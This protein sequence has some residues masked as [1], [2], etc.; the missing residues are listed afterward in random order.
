MK[1]TW[2]G[3]FITRMIAV[4]M[5]FAFTLISFNGCKINEPN[6]NID[7]KE[8]ETYTLERNGLS[9][10]KFTNKVDGYS[11]RIPNNMDVDM[12]LSGVRSVLE[13]KDEQIEIYRQDIDKSKGIT[14]QSYVN[15]S[16]AFLQNNVDYTVE[17]VRQFKLGEFDIS[18]AQWSREPLKRIKND[19][20][21]YAS[22]DIL[23]GESECFTFLFKS[24]KPYGVNNEAKD[25]L[26]VINSFNLIKKTKEPYNKKF[27]SIEN[28][29]WNRKTAQTYEKYFG[30]NSGLTWGIFDKEAPLDF[31]Q[32]YKTEKNL[33]FKFPI[34]LYYTGFIEDV[35]RHPRLTEALKNAK[36]ND[37]LLEL[38][39]QT[40]SQDANKG[41]MIYDVLNGKYDT[42]LNNYIKAIK[43]YG[44][45]ILFRIGNEMNGDWCV[46]SAY[47]TAKDTEIYKAFYKYIFQLFKE[48]GADNVIWIWN[49]NAKSFPDFKWNDELCYFPGNEY[50]DVI[51]MTNYNTGN[52]YE[53]ETW[54]E[55]KDLYD[56]IYKEYQQKYDYPFMITEF[57]SSSVGGDKNLWVANMFEHIKKYDKIKVA[58]WWSSYDL[59]INGNISRPYFID[60]TPELIKIFKENLDEYK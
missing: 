59:D 17:D 32:L 42:Y 6:N 22:V 15:Y 29:S 48:A 30:D 49:P 57:A 44:D 26:S 21:Y 8:Q 47:H 54:I 9:Y 33:N 19:R 7:I 12:S 16:N 58:I 60:E 13:N 50:V 28:N 46:Y 11:I 51:G 23:T 5:I 53:G 35:D 34:I 20:C 4:S 25:Y 55:F 3:F 45:P 1:N 31:T 2:T 10:N 52:Y 38:T 37:R 24:N 41:N 27:S 14:A 36:E 18:L 40:L 56:Q 39:L 43:E